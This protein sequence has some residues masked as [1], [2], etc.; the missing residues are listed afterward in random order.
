MSVH[1]TVYDF[2]NARNAE[3]FDAVTIRSGRIDAINYV[4]ALAKPHLTRPGVLSIDLGCGTGLFA[5][6]VGVRDI[7]GVDFS[8][9]LLTLARTRMDT[10]WEQDIFKLCLPHGSVDNVISLFVI[11]DYPSERKQEFFGLVFRLLRAGGLFFFAAYSPHDDRMGRL[12]ETINAKA[13]FKFHVYLED[14]TYYENAFRGHGFSIH[15]S[16]IVRSVGV[17]E[18]EPEPIRLRREFIVIVG[19]KP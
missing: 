19:L 12:R 14:Q 1:Q 6:I 13:G 16:E 18:V 8:S 5:H 9:P 11:D 15:R 3:E 10:V 2:W 7:I 17:Y 4:A